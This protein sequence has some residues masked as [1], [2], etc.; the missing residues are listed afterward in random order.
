MLGALHHL[1]G[2]CGARDAATWRDR[3]AALLESEGIVPE[4]RDRLAG[5]F[6]ASYGSWARSYR[7]CTPAAEVAVRRFLGDASKIAADVT[8]RYGQ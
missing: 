6:N 3:M 2:V 5:A 8:A 1:R 4:R 7:T